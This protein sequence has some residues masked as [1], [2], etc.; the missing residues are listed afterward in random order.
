M[1]ISLSIH[2]N[3]I[4]RTPLALPSAATFGWKSGTSLVTESWITQMCM[5]LACMLSATAVVV[6]FVNDGVML[7]WGSSSRGIIEVRYPGWKGVNHRNVAHNVRSNFE[8]RTSESL[9]KFL[10]HG[11]FILHFGDILCTY[12]SGAESNE[13]TKYRIFLCLVLYHYFLFLWKVICRSFSLKVFQNRF[14]SKYIRITE[15]KKLPTFTELG[16]FC[17]HIFKIIFATFFC[18]D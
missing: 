3:I 9:R 6:Q 15:Q 7:M 11:Q 8:T 18:F 12:Y 4:A 16:T 13:H 10:N 2:H 17:T 5:L 1:H 14:L